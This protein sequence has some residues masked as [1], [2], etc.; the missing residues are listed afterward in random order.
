MYT[1][2]IDLGGTNIV[3]GVVD[4]NYRIVAKEK[5]KT[6]MPR[7]ADAIIADMAK[8]ARAAAEKAG[9]SMEQVAF[10]GV[11]SPGVCNR[12]TG[13][14]ENANNLQFENVPIGPELN[15]LTGRPVLIENDA[16]A[17]MLGEAVAGAAKGAKDCVCITLGT[18]IGGGVLINGKIYSG[19]N[20]AGAEL[21]HTVIVV[22]GE[23][24]SCGRKGCWEAYASATALIRQTKRSMEAH[25]D[26][27]MWKIATAETVSGRTAFDAMRLGDAAA[28]EVVDQYIRYLSAGLVNAINVFQ[29]EILCIGG[30]IC[31]EGDTLL[32]PVKEYIAREVY[33]ANSPKQTKLCVASLGND[34]G[35]IGAAALGRIG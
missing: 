8:L 18:G 34:A 16:N 24:C 19:F 27:A 12:D 1:I 22:D 2:G 21:G 30:G 3:A 5:C 14:V 4:D 7:P 6:A 13:I 26:S 10:I 28:K 9:I 32:V 35:V 29:P 33:N 31:N 23:P 25:R 20:F 17:A 15:R 11:G